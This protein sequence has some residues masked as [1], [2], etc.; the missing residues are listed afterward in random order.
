MWEALGEILISSNAVAIL[1]FMA[2][3][4]V[5]GAILSKKGLIQIYTSAVSVGSADRERDNEMIA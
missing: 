2:F 1:L 4:V 5:F 3:I